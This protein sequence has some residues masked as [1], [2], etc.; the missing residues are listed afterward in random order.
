MEKSFYGVLHGSVLGPIIFN[1]F[2]RDLF[3]FLEGFVVV[4]VASY[5]DDTIPYNANKT[6]D[7]VIK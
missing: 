7:L 2:W 3:Y 5:A 6:N 1:I 4:T